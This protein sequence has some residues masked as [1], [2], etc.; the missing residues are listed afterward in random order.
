MQLRQG[1]G[2]FPGLF[3]G[4]T[5]PLLDLPQLRFPQQLP[6]LRRDEAAF[7]G[8]VLQETVPFQFLVSPLGGDDGSS[9]ASS[10]IDGRASPAANAP[11]MICSFT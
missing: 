7:A 11:D 4:L 10:R 8:D 2:T 5:Q 3:H 9:F 1:K 6:V